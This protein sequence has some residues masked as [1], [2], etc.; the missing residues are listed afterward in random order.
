MGLLRRGSSG[1]GAVLVVVVCVGCIAATAMAAAAGGGGGGGECPKYKDSKQPLNKRIDDLLRRMTL[2][3][4]IGQMS[5]IER[6]NAT[7]D[8][9]R[10]YFIG[11][12]DC[13]LVLAAEIHIDSC[14]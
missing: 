2:A 8:V 5:Q 3:E 13:F 9:M 4:K 10:N 6:E 12:L 7:F 14:I 11:I 1:G